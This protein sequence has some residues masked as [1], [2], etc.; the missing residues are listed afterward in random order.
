MIVHVIDMRESGPDGMV[1]V[2]EPHA[3]LRSADVETVP[4]DGAWLLCAIEGCHGDSAGK[5]TVHVRHS[6]RLDEIAYLCEPHIRL[7]ASGEQLRLV[8]EPRW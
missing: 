7:H 5:M 6:R 8:V 3:E 2:I 1:A 4:V